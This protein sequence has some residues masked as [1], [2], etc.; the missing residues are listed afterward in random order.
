[1]ILKVR[2]K[3]PRIGAKKLFYLLGKDLKTLK[4]RYNPV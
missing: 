4:N 1:M 3:M 2:A